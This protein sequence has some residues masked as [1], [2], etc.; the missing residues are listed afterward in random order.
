MVQTLLLRSCHLCP[1]SMSNGGGPSAATVLPLP[2]DG[3]FAAGRTWGPAPTTVPQALCLAARA[4][5]QG[6]SHGNHTE[7]P[8]RIGWL[9]GGES[10]KIQPSHAYLAPTIFLPLEVKPLLSYLSSLLAFVCHVSPSVLHVGVGTKKGKENWVYLE[11]G[12]HLALTELWETRGGGGCWR[13]R[14]DQN[15][16]LWVPVLAE[17]QLF[18]KGQKENIF[19]FMSSMVS[20]TTTQLCHCS[21]K[22]R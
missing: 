8:R 4:S 19:G 2:G 6:R 1:P 3:T 11:E 21:R 20:A 13:R 10:T 7:A 18:L 15:A 14:Q 17:S 5:Q 9:N 16:G 12:R 22:Q